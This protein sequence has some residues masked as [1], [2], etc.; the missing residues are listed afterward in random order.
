MDYD[1]QTFERPAFWRLPQQKTFELPYGRKRVHFSEQRLKQRRSLK[2]IEWTDIAKSQHFT[3]QLPPPVTNP[4]HKRTDS[5][6]V[7]GRL[8]INRKRETVSGTFQCQTHKF[9]RRALAIGRGGT[10][11]MK[12]PSTCLTSGTKGTICEE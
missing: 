5:A 8:K 6:N 10:M 3:G 7:C 2:P 4:H 9:D 1:R 11:A 12:V